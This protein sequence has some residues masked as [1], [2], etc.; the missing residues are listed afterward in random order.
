VHTSNIVF[1]KCAPPLVV[2]VPAC[3]EILAMGLSARIIQSKQLS[4]SSTLL[5]SSETIMFF[6]FIASVTD[7]WPQ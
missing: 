6:Y 4:N 7:D 3:C 1:K 2:F 5:R